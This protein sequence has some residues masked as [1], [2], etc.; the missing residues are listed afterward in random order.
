MIHRLVLTN[1]QAHQHLEADFHPGLNL[2]VGPN[3]SGKTTVQR[4][5]LYALFGTGAVPVKA[6]NLI[7]Q[8][9]QTMEVELTISLGDRRLIISRGP[10]GA[11]CYDATG[12]PVASGQN[13]VTAYVES[14][15]GTTSKAFLAFQVARQNEAASIL[16]LGSTKLSQHIEQVCGVDLVDRAI[17]HLRLGLGDVKALEQEHVQTSAALAEVTATAEHARSELQAVEQQY[18][19]LQAQK[20]DQDR[21]VN[22]LQTTLAELNRQQ[23]AYSSRL[24]A[25]N[26]LT[27]TLEALPDVAPVDQAELDRIDA[28]VVDFEWRLG[29]LRTELARY[30]HAQSEVTRCESVVD[31]LP[32]LDPNAPSVED[33]GNRFDVVRDRRS[34]LYRLIE[35]TRRERD[36]GVCAA[37]QRPF[38]AGH[39]IAALSALLASYEAEY[40]ALDGPLLDAQKAFQHAQQQAQISREIDQAVAQ[41]EAAVETLEQLNPVS[42]E[43]V[44]D[45]DRARL[46]H[47]HRRSALQNDINL[48][49]QRLQIEAQIAA[50]P[51]VGES[52]EP[53]IT[54]LHQ[55]LEANRM[56]G[57]QLSK[58]CAELEAKRTAFQV[59][60]AG[61]EA[62]RAGLE[63][64]HAALQVRLA[65]QRQRKALISVLAENR[66][67]FMA[68][69]WQRL[70]QNAS[71]FSDAATEGAVGELEREDDTFY[72]MEQPANERR[73]IELA[74]GH[75]QAVLGV[76]IKLAL[77]EAVGS[78]FDVILLDE[79][80]AGATEENALRLTAALKER[81]GQCILISHR[82]SDTTVADH[83]LELTSAHHA[84]M[85]DS[86]SH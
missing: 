20:A 72:F 55:Q 31:R 45:L 11:V 74:S 53:L 70:L 35:Q 76:A 22:D 63:A 71:R 78:V 10:K 42:P 24:S 65:E 6:A 1:F 2:I 37:C 39:D 61:L 85:R 15:L 47:Q 69:A 43:M 19:A 86:D 3:W 60:N 84:P 40:T 32:A 83:V 26:A 36:S 52:V 67:Q 64:Q 16:T 34:E 56:L 5:I 30:Q 14:L 54:A 4:A 80:S 17:A 77:A 27:Q 82:E 21:A 38:E 29:Q 46:Q 49:A 41:L 66:E 62:Q 59:Q 51:E 48:H 81:S 50:L 7:N 12:M 68:S 8:S 9:A 23:S 73:P 28:E 18:A 75:Q 57:S 13:Q 58:Q 33:A 25:R 79:V 44:S